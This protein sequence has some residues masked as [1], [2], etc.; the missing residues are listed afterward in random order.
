MTQRPSGSQRLLIFIAY[1]GFVSLGL[2]DTLIGVAWPS[3]RDN[4][5]LQQ[6]AAA[7]VFFG[8][9]CSYFLSSFFTGRLLRFLGIG[10]LLA[11]SSLLVAVSGFGYALAPIWVLFAAAS[12]LHGV[13]SGAIDAGLNHYVAHH[14]SA[15]HMNWLHACYAV[16]ATLGP[17]IMT[18]MIAW[19]G[20]WRGGYLI[21]AI[22]LFALSVLFTV[23][24]RKWEDG[25][26]SRE[27]ESPAS[28]SVHETLRHPLVWLQ[29]VIF[30]IYTGLE[31]T[32]GQ[33]SFTLMTESRHIQKDFAGLSVTTYWASIC[34]GR[35]LF[36]FLVDRIGVDRLIRGSLLTAL[37]GAG[38][39][40]LRPPEAVQA[41][42]LALS[43]LGL[44]AIYPCLMTRT[45]QRLGKALASHAIGFQ[46]GAA[47]LGAAL[48]PSLAGLLGQKVGLEFVAAA[49]VA[50]ALTLF[51]LHE[52]LMMR[53]PKP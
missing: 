46:V 44:A 28:A 43:G 24:R 2:P 53:S 29:I 34:L 38:L 8:T 7:F 12:L 31:V 37:L 39:F 10:T 15:R 33:W 17:L 20:S 30:F 22:T 18:G 51:L 9:G 50:L 3:V 42:A 19:N 21:V 5:H 26:E 47:M 25:N 1:I 52:F 48:L 16:G 13:G 45:P 49:A 4:F 14:L 40:A 41:V 6:S 35:I 36:G 23:T 27:S 11:A 32:I